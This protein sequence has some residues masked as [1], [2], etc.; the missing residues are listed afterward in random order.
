MGGPSPSPG[1]AAAPQQSG[2]GRPDE[3]PDLES[4]ELQSKE[5]AAWTAHKAATGQVRRLESM[6]TCVSDTWC[7][8]TYT[9]HCVHWLR[10]QWA[11]QVVTAGVGFSAMLC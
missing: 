2:P 7:F 8:S 3:G 11:C 10:C 9:A 5:A 1:Q 4:S 6:H